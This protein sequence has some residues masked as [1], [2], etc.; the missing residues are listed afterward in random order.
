MKHR[1]PSFTMSLLALAPLFA[2]NVGPN[3]ERPRVESP[4]SFRGEVSDPAPT[5]ASASLA[6]R[7]WWQLFE[8]ET[9]EW[10]IR[11]ALQQ[12]YDV[13][14]A[15]ARLLEAE[16]QLG[17]A[18]ADQLPTLTAG[19][20]ADGRRS[21][22]A[23]AGATNELRAEVQASWEL[24]F[25]GKFRRAS[26]AARADLLATEWGRRAA[27][28]SLVAQVASAYFNLGALDQQR[29]IAEGALA[30]RRES[31]RLT[32]R[33]EQS[34]AGS[35]I[36]VFQA[37]ELVQLAEGERI[38]LTRQIEQQENLLSTLLGLDPRPITRGRPFSAQTLP[39]TVPAGLPSA[40]L[41]R[42]PDIL[43]A[44]Q[45]LVS[46]NAQVGVARADQFPSIELTGSGG[47]ASNALVALF[48]SPV[49]FLGAAGKLV[50]P[51][52]DGGRRSAQVEAADARARQA[53]LSY[54]STI[55]Q[56]MREV[57]DALVGFHR[58]RELATS[59]EALVEAARQALTL[60]EAR[61][62]GGSSSYLEVLD[63]NGRRLDAELSQVR[64]RLDVLLAYVD[65]YRAL[66]GGW[67]V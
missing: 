7:R 13:R 29:A 64:A 19:V 51:L 21:F 17:L 5:P 49:A 41:E 31:L 46:A 35:L 26:E 8:D 61:Y 6:D 18:R 48:T 62:A 54:R 67:E 42:R 3:Y 30:A 24:D 27:C 11:T 23:A 65:V 38:D 28:Q 14:I 4:A 60:V 37:R 32:E 25:W 43:A 55:L 56:A 2:C 34:G 22:G 15:A 16:A 47:V 20:G 9:L 1:L 39:P 63:A 36:D 12:N 52:F 33:R 58:N 57:S 44:E 10:L 50:Q 40:L 59:R 45:Q 66:G 53:E